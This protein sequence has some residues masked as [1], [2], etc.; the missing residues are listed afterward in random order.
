[1]LINLSL[2]LQIVKAV[3]EENYD[4]PT[5]NIA[6]TLPVSFYLRAHSL[7]TFL[8]NNF[9][10]HVKSSLPLGVV[11]VGVK[12]VWKYVFAEKVA[13]QVNK[14]FSTESD[15]RIQVGIEYVDDH[16]ESSCL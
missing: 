8:L 12:D 6:F 7:L 2:L 9:P 11:T 5:F 1:M 4:N 16:A 10:G 15:L 14:M 3:E 13:K